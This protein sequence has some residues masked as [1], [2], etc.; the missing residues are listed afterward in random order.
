MLASADAALLIG[1]P[2]LFADARALGA[3]K[4]DLGAAWTAMTGLPFVWAF[5]SGPR[6]CR[7]RDVVRLL[8]DAARDGMRHT[9]A[10]ADAYC[11]GD[12][13]IMQVARRVP[14]R[15]PA[16]SP[17]RARDR[18]PL[19]CT[20]AR[21]RRWALPP[22]RRPSFFLGAELMTAKDAEFLLDY[23]YWA[24]DRQ[25]NAVEH[26][27]SEQFLRPLGSSFS[28]VRDTLVHTY[29]AEW[30]WLERWAGRSPTSQIPLDRF[31]DFPTLKS[32]WNELERQTRAFV[33]AVGEG[34]FDAYAAIPSAQRHRG[35]ESARADAAARR[36][37][38]QLPSR[39][40]HDPAAPDGL[41]AAGQ[42]GFHYVHSRARFLDR[43][44]V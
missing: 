15:T 19:D 37:S 10:I 30:I 22:T 32:A 12:A 1:D 6:G 34:G 25:L 24:R 20:T 7:R 5:W 16:V 42:P 29:S 14:A 38:R 31:P 40:G 3:E 18:R 41:R 33:R 39:P 23:H 2:A 13:A 27:T 21:P 9:D 4:I 17:A 28:S 11:A 44:R 8:Q 36:Q 26:L 35:P 43:M